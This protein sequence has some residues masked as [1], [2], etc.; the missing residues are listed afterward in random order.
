MIGARLL[1]MAGAITLA[2]AGLAAGALPVG[3]FEVWPGPDLSEYA[4]PA[5][6]YGYFGVTLLVAAWLW[7]GRVETDRR[8]QLTTLALWCAPLLLAP[9]L[10]SRDAYAYLAQGAMVVSRIDVYKD[11]VAELGGQLAAQVPGMWQHTPTP[12]GPVFLAMAA[13]VSALAG[14]KIVLGVLGLRLVAV[15]GVALLAYFLPRLAVQCGVDPGRAL[16][17]GVL[18]PLVPL[19][20]VAGAHNDALMMGLLVAGLSIAFDRRFAAA[21]VLVTLAALVKAPAAAGLL[22]VAALWW[23][24]LPKRAALVNAAVRTGGIAAATTAAVTWATGTGYGWVASLRTPMSP[25]S[26]SLSTALGRASK[27]IA[28]P[29]LG[30]AAMQFWIWCGLAATAAIVAYVW[31]RRARLGPVYAIGLGLAA[32]ALLGPATRPWYALWGVIPLAAAAPEGVVR[33]WAAAGSAMLTLLVLPSG[34]GPDGTQFALAAAG[35]LLAGIVLAYGRLWAE[36]L[37]P[38]YRW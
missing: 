33:R 27:L 20:L 18:N 28:P 29:G 35:V 15:G 4:L 31:W 22:V 38:A 24:Y 1:G 34:F 25:R 3:G 16:W 12:Y 10:F 11:G 2:G 5:V 21:A 32:V 7:A 37:A 23:P 19:H 8:G 30:D 17:L 26:W 14:A 6:L 13:A 9:P 36:T